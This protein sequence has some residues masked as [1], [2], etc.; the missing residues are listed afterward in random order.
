MVHGPLAGTTHFEGG[1]AMLKFMQETP[2]DPPKP[3]DGGGDEGGDEGSGTA[4]E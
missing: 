4:S 2:P 3:D 1:N